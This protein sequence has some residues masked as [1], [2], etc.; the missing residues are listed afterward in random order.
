MPR[1][2][3]SKNKT[4]LTLDEQIQAAETRAEKARNELA[5]AEEELKALRTLRDEEAKK[6]LMGVIASSGKSIA[7]V[8]DMIRGMESGE[9]SE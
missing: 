2:K 6:E 7:E 4:R 5:A 8:I 9:Q 1:T 3:G